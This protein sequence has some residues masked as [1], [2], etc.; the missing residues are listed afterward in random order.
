MRLVRIKRSP[1]GKSLLVGV[2][3][4]PTPLAT[5]DLE[6]LFVEAYQRLHG[7]VL[8]H[9]ERF[10]STDDACDAV[11]DAMAA[12]WYRWPRLT[13][14]QQQSE[15]YVFG[16]VHHCVFAKLRETSPLVS[17]EDAERELDRQAM[18]ALPD[19]TGR[20]TAADVLDAALAAM[21][22]RRREVLLLVYEHS[23][24][25][26]EAAEALGLAVGSIKKHMYLAVED[27]RAAFTRAGFRIASPQPARL[28][29]P[30]GE[31]T[32]D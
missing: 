8:N 3:A 32:N 4:P 25:Y 28:P 7:P 9:A 15:G 23:F 10:L 22:P 13:P 30:K 5:V 17:L 14:E 6:Q 1:E 12:L 20:D 21:P 29:S 19:L 18:A 27:L 11:G 2:V 24:T 26:Q 16:V 31:V